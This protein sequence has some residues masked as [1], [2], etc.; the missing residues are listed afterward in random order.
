MFSEQTYADIA[1]LTD[2][3]LTMGVFEVVDRVTVI[4]GYVQ[5]SLMFPGQAGYQASVAASI[6]DLLQTARR[7]RKQELVAALEALARTMEQD[8]A[9]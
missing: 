9:A 8:R 4:R 3:A 1:R 2:D 5:L 7:Y 6:R